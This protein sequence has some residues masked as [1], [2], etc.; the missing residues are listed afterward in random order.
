MIG[1]SKNNRDNYPR[2]FFWTHEKESRVKFNLGLSANR[3]SNNWALGYMLLVSFLSS[4]AYRVSTEFA[5]TDTIMKRLDYRVKNKRQ[6][7]KS[8]VL[9]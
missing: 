1:S 5:I 6:L 7:K 8:Y 2:K 3:P 4:Q 9:P